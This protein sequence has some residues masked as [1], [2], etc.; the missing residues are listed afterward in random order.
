MK[1]KNKSSGHL[2]IRLEKQEDFR[3][4]EELTREAFWDVYVPGC[5]EHILLHELRDGDDFLP[6]LSFVAE[7]DGKLAG[8]IAYTQGTIET[9]TGAL[10]RPIS[11]GPISVL[12][13]YQQTGVGTALIRH[14]LARARE[15]G[16]NQVLIYG[17]PRYYSRHG[18]HCAEYYGIRDSEG[19]YAA[20]LLALELVLH[21]RRIL[22]C[23]PSSVTGFYR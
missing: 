15:L 4:V 13:E 17:D 1:N 20:A 5:V 19:F 9:D 16:Y 12:P 8:H 14:S 21:R 23:S 11:F 10:F 6:E 22:E 18:F 7:L 2:Q 3:A